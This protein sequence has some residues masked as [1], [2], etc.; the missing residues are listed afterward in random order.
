MQPYR[1]CNARSGAVLVYVAIALVA[2]IGMAAL[3][4]DLGQLYVAKQR[5]QN[6]CDGAVL[7]G[8]QE[9]AN[10]YLET[11][12]EWAARQAADDCAA[13]NNEVSEAAWKVLLPPEQTGEN[14]SVEGVDV[15]FPTTVTDDAGNTFTVQ[16][17]HAITAEG[18]VHVEFGFAGIFGFDSKDVQASATAILTGVDNMSEP[19]IPLGVSDQIASSGIQFGDPWELTV[20]DW[21]SGFLG[22]GN[23]LSLRLSEDDQGVPDFVARLAGEAD[24][25]EVSVGEEVDTEPGGSGGEGMGSKVYEGLIGK[26]NPNGKLIEEGRLLKET[27]PRFAP[28]DIY[29][30]YNPDAWQN[31]QDSYDEKTKMYDPTQRLVIMPIIEDT[32][33]AVTGMKPVLVVGFAGFFINRVYDGTD[34][35][36]P[37]GEIEGFFVQGI[38]QS[39]GELRWILPEPGWPINSSNL[40]LTTRLI[41]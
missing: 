36:H 37:K 9:L 24:P 21:Q 38:I 15:A 20:P 19:V 2:L 6:V 25:A 26:F 11:D 34:G 39:D 27:D 5:A 32:P 31:W 40:I 10:H 41:S 35:V 16:S 22:P 8:V 30:G 18:C 33:D 23:W 1:V 13:T 3:A 17:Y 4:I 29:T 14:P 28:T 7:S 12:V